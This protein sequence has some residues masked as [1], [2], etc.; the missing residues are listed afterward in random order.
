MRLLD[1]H[2]GRT[3]VESRIPAERSMISALP[4]RIHASH[5]RGSR[6]LDAIPR[7]RHRAVLAATLSRDRAFLHVAVVA[8][9]SRSL[10]LSRL[11]LSSL[12][13]PVKFDLT[14]LRSVP[15][16]CSFYAR[17]AFAPPTR[18]RRPTRFVALATAARPATCSALISRRPAPLRRHSK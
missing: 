13:R 9:Y 11:V 8:V 7:R 6:E 5:L 14:A 15:C 2:P 1:N 16:R 10:L 17:A 18:R 4:S 12:S 3:R